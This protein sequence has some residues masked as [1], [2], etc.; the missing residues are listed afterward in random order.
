MIYVLALVL[1][2]AAGLLFW[3]PGLLVGWI[4]EKLYIRFCKWSE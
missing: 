1:I 2:I 4:A 3:L